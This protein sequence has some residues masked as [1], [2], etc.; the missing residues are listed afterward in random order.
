[1]D[2]TSQIVDERDTVGER[3]DITLSFSVTELRQLRED[4]LLTRSREAVRY[5]L[6]TAKDYAETRVAP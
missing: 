1:M 2:A 4:A 5:Y 3:V 6:A